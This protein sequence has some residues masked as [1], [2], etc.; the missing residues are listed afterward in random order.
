MNPSSIPTTLTTLAS[1]S[2]TMTDISKFLSILH[3]ELP[4]KNTS[5]SI[6]AITMLQMQLICITQQVAKNDPEAKPQNL[7]EEIDEMLVFYIR[8]IVGD[9]AEYDF[10]ISVTPKQTVH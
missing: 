1:I 10:E 9:D 6:E 5:K 8:Q 7:I 2:Q 4:S 3:S